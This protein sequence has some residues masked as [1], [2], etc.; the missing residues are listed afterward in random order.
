MVKQPKVFIQHMLDSINLMEDILGL[1][2][3][4]YLKSIEEARKEYKEGK[5]TKL[6]DLE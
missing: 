6:S 1:S 3:E 4:N 5:I 2:S